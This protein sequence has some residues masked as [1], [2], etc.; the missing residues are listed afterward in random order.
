M[1]RYRY[2]TFSYQTPPELSSAPAPKPQV[3]II[4]AGPVGL[5]A[6]ID[7]ALHGIKSIVLDDNDVVSVGSRAICWSKRSLEIFNRL[8]IG[9]LMVEKGVTWQVGRVFRGARELYSFDLLPEHGHDMP[10]FINLQQ[11]YVEE[12]LV[13]RAAQFPDLIELRWKNKVTGVRQ[14]LDCAHLTIE[15]P[16]GTYML[17]APFVVACDGARSTL[18]TML[19]LD[20]VGQAFQERFLIADVEMEADFPSERWFWFEPD[21]H[22]GQSALIHKQPDN[23]YRI[24][25]QLGPDADP[26]EEAKPERVMPR[27]KAA[28]GD[29]AFKI[30]WVSVYSFQCRR[31]ARFVYDRVIFA[32][33]AAHIVSPFGARGGNGGIQDADNLAWKLAA[34]L[35]GDAPISLLESYDEERCH[36]ADENIL[37]SARATTF[38]TPKSVTERHFR[39]AVLDLAGTHAFARKLVNSGRLSVP[40][41][42]HDMSLQTPAQDDTGLMPGCAC[43]DAPVTNRAGTADYLLRHLGHDFVLLVLGEGAFSAPPGVRIVHIGAGE[44]MSDGMGL[45]ADRYGWNCAYLVRPDQHIA[46]R[47]SASNIGAVSNAWQRALGKGG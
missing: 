44:E 40:C 30:D 9:Q 1:A 15:T 5:T 3:V 36:G 20:F 11:Y 47:F 25:F 28:I 32:G 46:A 8:G 17:A 35:K 43:P 24:D 7:L 29:R 31:L 12:Y 16:D 18:R 27:I 6:A 4:G 21:F 2:Q 37:N 33:D 34:I 42:L 22:P 19:G 23:I 39:D 38:M 45:I 13:A 10:A 14:N 26:H 41:A